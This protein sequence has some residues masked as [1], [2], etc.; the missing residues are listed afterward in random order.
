MTH[1]IPLTTIA[2]FLGTKLDSNRKIAFNNK[3]ILSYKDLK[4]DVACLYD[5][6]LDSKEQSCG[7]YFENSYYFIVTFLALLHAKKTPVLLPNLQ[8]GFIED[9]KDDIDLLITDIR[10]AL[11]SI[12]MIDYAECLIDEIKEVKFNSLNANTALFNIFTSGTTG[13]PKKIIKSLNQIDSEISILEKQWGKQLGQSPVVATVSHQHVYGLIFRVLWPLSAGRC[14][15]DSTFQFPNDLFRQV[16]LMHSSVV[17]SSPA[18]LKRIPELEHVK[19]SAQNISVIFSSGGAL[20]Q[21]TAVSIQNVLNKN[22]IEIFGSSETGGVAYRQQDSTNR[23]TCW[24]PLPNVEIKRCAAEGTLMVRS[25]FVGTDEYYMMGDMIEVAQDGNFMLFGRADRVVKVEEK[26]LS[27][28]EVEEKLKLSELVDD[29]VAIVVDR[30]R[31]VVAVV[32]V[33]TSSGENYLL[34]N[35]KKQLVDLLRRHLLDYFENLLLPRKWR[36]VANLPFNAQGK[37]TYSQLSELFTSSDNSSDSDVTESSSQK[38]AVNF[39]QVVKA[40]QADNKVILHMIVPAELI[41][42]EGHFPDNPLLPGAVLIDWAIHYGKQQFTIEGE[43]LQ[44]EAIKFHEF[45]LPGD[46]FSLS[47]EYDS[48]KGKL[49][50]SYDSEKGRHSSG[51]IVFGAKR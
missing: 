4:R 2:E 41:Y 21:S 6:I 7:V 15:I 33:L 36:F 5:V 24:T 3:Q 23:S 17:I 25:P 9:I 12:K 40:E 22:V 45:I 10:P 46:Q 26:R 14:F 39:P 48:S 1:T 50:Y 19:S 49:K 34:Q 44:M 27:L 8:T 28:T 35:N 42:F 29:C 30:K 47:L 18:L 31:S 11:N 51:R 38:D 20:P 43:F 32:V 13:K 37:I 16:E